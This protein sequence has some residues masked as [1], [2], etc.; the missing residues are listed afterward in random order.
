MGWPISELATCLIED[1]AGRHS[2]TDLL[3]LSSS[4]FGR[5][6]GHSAHGSFD[7]LRRRG[8]AP[9]RDR[10]SYPFVEPC[11][12]VRVPEHDSTSIIK[13]NG[14]ERGTVLATRFALNGSNRLVSPPE[15]LP[16][17]L[18]YVE[19]LRRRMRVRF[20]ATSTSPRSSTSEHLVAGPQRRQAAREDFRPPSKRSGTWRDCYQ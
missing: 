1:R 7:R 18:L 4:H 16:K 15:P 2:G 14:G 9:S 20:G 12:R 8:R 3:T 11:R 13:T 19:R 17:R 10:K 5:R 6:A